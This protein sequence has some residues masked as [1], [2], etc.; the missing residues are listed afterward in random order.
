MIKYRTAS[1]NIYNSVAVL[2]AALAFL[3][4]L[5]YQVYLLFNK[6]LMG[7]NML[8]NIFALFEIMFLCAGAFFSFKQLVRNR[9]IETV[10][11]AI[12]LVASLFSFIVFNSIL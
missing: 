8:Y 9:H 5:I 2:F 12:L 4:L 3:L 7:Y 6:H 1:D 11:A 10:T